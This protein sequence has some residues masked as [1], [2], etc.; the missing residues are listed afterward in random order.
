[1]K[2]CCFSG[3]EQSKIVGMYKTGAKRVKF[4]AKL[5]HP[6]TIVYIITKKFE[7]SGIMEGKKSTKIVGT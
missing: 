7:S 1:M 6:K 2:T 4:L 3:E 5:D